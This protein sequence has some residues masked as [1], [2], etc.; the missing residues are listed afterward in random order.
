MESELCSRDVMENFVGVGLLLANTLDLSKLGNTRLVLCLIATILFPD[1][2][3]MINLFPP[4]K[5]TQQPSHKLW[6][7]SFSSHQSGSIEVAAKP[8]RVL[9]V[10][11]ITYRCQGLSLFRSMLAL[12]NVSR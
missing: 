1:D 2:M 12:C 6:Q 4:G 10:K 3:P 5:L 11:E 9:E 7:T 8:M